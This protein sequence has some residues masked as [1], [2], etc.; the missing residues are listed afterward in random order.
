MYDY[1]DEEDEQAAFVKPPTMGNIL[2]QKR[3]NKEKKA[4]VYEL[5]KKEGRDGNGESD[6]EDV[7]D[8]D[9]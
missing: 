7:E 9:D 8:E 6:W 5:K 2:E 3:K 4:K 1:E